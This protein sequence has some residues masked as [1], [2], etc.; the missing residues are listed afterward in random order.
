MGSLQRQALYMGEK[1][2]SLFP[3][4]LYTEGLTFFPQTQNLMHREVAD[5]LQ[6]SDAGH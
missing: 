1:Y 4:M 5:I 6:P 3:G 2:E